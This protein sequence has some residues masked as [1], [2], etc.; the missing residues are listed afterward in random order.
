MNKVTVGDAFWMG[1]DLAMPGRMLCVELF[2]RVPLVSLF[3]ES[4]KFC[5]SKHTRSCLY[6]IFLKV[7]SYPNLPCYL[8]ST[9]SLEPCCEKG[10]YFYIML[11]RGCR[12]APMNLLDFGT[13]CF[14]DPE[15]H[16]IPLPGKHPS[17]RAESPELTA[18]FPPST[19][20]PWLPSSTRRKKKSH[21]W[22]RRAMQPLEFLIWIIY[23]QNRHE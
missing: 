5:T 1:N 11:W 2:P 7:H 20:T 8:R 19:L 3:V 22:N 15:V 21:F 10:P 17:C 12:W 4:A 9:E 13:Y 14:Y 23:S 16:R 6:T 18:T